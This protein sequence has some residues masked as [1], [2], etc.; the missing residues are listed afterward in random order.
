MESKKLSFLFFIIIIAV[1]SC[2]NTNA[3]K[4]VPVQSEAVKPAEE[5]PV[6]QSVVA[7]QPVVIEKPVVIEQPV[8]IEKPVTAEQPAAEVI[9]IQE[10]TRQ[11]YDST[12]EEVRKFIEELNKIISSRNYSAWK[13]ALSPE[14]FDEISSAENL[15]SISDMP[16]MKTRKIVLKTT[17]DYFVHVVVPARANSRVDDIEFITRTR[18]KAFSVNV[19]RQGEEQRLVL[20]DLEKEGNSWIIIN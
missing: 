9:N 17:E 13:A 8:V 15:Q 7:E 12:M 19:N 20:Y 16:A 5:K 4:E 1:V 18:V 2:Q 14:Y 3:P 10:I 11:H 6:V